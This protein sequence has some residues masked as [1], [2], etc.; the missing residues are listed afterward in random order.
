MYNLYFK[1]GNWILIHILGQVFLLLQIF[2]A[3]KED[4]PIYLNNTTYFFAYALI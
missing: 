3:I 2:V 4:M 1:Q